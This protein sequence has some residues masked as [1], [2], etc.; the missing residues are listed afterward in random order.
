MHNP[1]HIVLTGA[2]S[3]IGAALAQAYAAPGVTLSLLGRDATRLAQVAAAAQKSGAT[4]VTGTADVTVR[5]ALEPWLRA[6]DDSCPVDLL[7]A[8]AGISAGTGG[9]GETAEQASRIFAVNIEGVLNTVHALLP[10]MQARQRGQIAVMSSLAGFRG[11]PGAPTYCASKA[12][13]RLYGEALR[14]E[15]A[16][17]GIAVNVI[18]PG[19]VATPMTAVNN[20]T[21][22][23]LMSAERAATIIKNG[24]AQNRARIAFPFPTYAAVW[25]LAALPPGLTDWLMARL[26]KKPQEK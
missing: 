15:L 4:V 11:M 5:A 22:P 21:M 14:G 25:L 7:I 20:Y 17:Q 23:F 13:V 9:G 1:H 2:S 6:R 24:L 8:N 19:Y 10:A 12:A 3:G 18:C 16:A 26:P